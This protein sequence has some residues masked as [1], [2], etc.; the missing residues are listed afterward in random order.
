MSLLDLS[1]SPEVV[2]G[3]FVRIRLV[4]LSAVEKLSGVL[5]Q[6]NAKKHDEKGLFDSIERFGFVDPPHWDATLNDGR[7]GIVFGNG[8]TESIV[9]ALIEARK[10]GLEPPRGIPTHEGEWLIPIS[11]GVNQESEGEAI[12][13]GIDHNNLTVSGSEFSE[14]DIAKMWD[15]EGYVGLLSSIADLDIMPITVDAE[16]IGNLLLGLD[17]AEMNAPTTSG[18][19]ETEDIEEMDDDLPD[20]QV[21]MVQ[22]FLD[23]ET[24]PLFM[25]AISKLQAEQDYDNLTHCVLSVICEAAN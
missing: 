13:L 16:A 14:F 15:M 20:S 5:W 6:D 8:R 12:A 7:G 24:H 22:L 1:I 21:K 11:F 10:N 23:K 19:Q 3:D 2:E 25:E 4:P 9:S 18:E 17:R